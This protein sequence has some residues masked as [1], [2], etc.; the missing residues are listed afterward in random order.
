MLRKSVAAGGIAVALG[1]A[2]AGPAQAACE[3]LAQCAVETVQTKV[4]EIRQTVDGLDEFVVQTV[5]DTKAT[6][7]AAVADA[8]KRV[9]DTVAYVDNNTVTDG[10]N[11][12]L[13]GRSSTTGTITVSGP[14]TCHRLDRDGARDGSDGSGVRTGRFSLQVDA[15]PATACLYGEGRGTLSITLTGD[16][17]AIVSRSVQLLLADGDGVLWDGGT[18]LEGFGVGTATLTPT[19]TLNGGWPLTDCMYAW[20]DYFYEGT[21]TVVEPL[22]VDTP[23]I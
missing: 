19:R 2:S 12:V 3:T 21:Y 22:P 16:T 20:G 1:L 23:S 15:P 6:V 18:A 7:D 11:C 14:A 10:W 4:A 9:N 13:E 8:V 17:E 5:N